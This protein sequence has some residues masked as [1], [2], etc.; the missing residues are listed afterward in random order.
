MSFKI[1]FRWTSKGE[2]KEI[3]LVDTDKK[4]TIGGL[5]SALALFAG[6]FFGIPA[7]VVDAV[8]GL[9]LLVLGYYSNKK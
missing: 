6:G 8:A 3:V 5:V 9:G 1:Y 7:P 2:R 4:T